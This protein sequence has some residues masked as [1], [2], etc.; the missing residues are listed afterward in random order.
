[1]GCDHSNKITAIEQYLHEPLSK[2]VSTFQREPGPSCVS[3][4]QIK[5][6]CEKYLCYDTIYER[7]VKKEH[8]GVYCIM[9]DS[10]IWPGA[11][12]CGS[13]AYIIHI[14]YVAIF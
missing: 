11:V 8:D 4:K 12:Y 1:M 13:M 10:M 9:T 5:W 2:V 14:R 6:R 7:Q 3:Y